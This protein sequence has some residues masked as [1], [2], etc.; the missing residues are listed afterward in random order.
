MLTGGAAG[1]A[2]EGDTAAGEEFEVCTAAVFEASR[3]EIRLSGW[4]M[5]HATPAARRTVAAMPMKRPFFEPEAGTGI[6]APDSPS[7]CPPKT[8]VCGRWWG[9]GTL[10]VSA[11]PKDGS[12]AG[13][14]SESAGSSGAAAAV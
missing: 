10:S 5:Y 6:A 13:R 14:E 4:R 1:R 2:A 8:A 3:L 9:T 7:N 12:E 11:S